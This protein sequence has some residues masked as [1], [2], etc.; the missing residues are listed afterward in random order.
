MVPDIAAVKVHVRVNNIHCVPHVQVICVNVFHYS[1]TRVIAT[2]HLILA[3][4][5][6]CPNVTPQF[7]SLPPYSHPHLNSMKRASN[8]LT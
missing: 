7:F 4:R 1:Y 6:C 8:E 2:P 5:F 3:I